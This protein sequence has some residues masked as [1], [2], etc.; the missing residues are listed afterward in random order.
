MECLVRTN[1]S[2]S[3]PTRPW[4]KSHAEFISRGLASLA[5]A[6]QT[7]DY[8]DAEVLI[9]NLQQRLDLAKAKQVLGNR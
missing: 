9:A 3:P 6:R 7:G 5:N 8:V 1:T 2:I 4:P